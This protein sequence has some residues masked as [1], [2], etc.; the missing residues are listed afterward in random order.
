MATARDPAQF[1]AAGACPV[2]DALQI[3]CKLAV[4]AFSLAAST[5]RSLLG[6]SATRA[7]PLAPAFEIAERGSLGI[8]LTPQPDISVGRVLASNSGTVRFGWVDD[9]PHWL[10]ASGVVG[11]LVA[12]VTRA[13]VLDVAIDDAGTFAFLVSRLDASGRSLAIV[14]EDGGE[15][16][17]AQGSILGATLVGAGPSVV[18]VETPPTSAAQALSR[19]IRWD[20][21]GQRELL[22]EFLESA[23]P[24]TL[25]AAQ[26]GYAASIDLQGYTGNA[27]TEPFAERLLLIEGDGTQRSIWESSGKYFG[28]SES[29]TV[30]SP[31]ICPLETTSQT[32]ADSTP[33]GL[34]AL[35]STSDAKLWLARVSGPAEQ[36]CKWATVSGCFETLPCQ[37]AQRLSTRYTL[38]LFLY[39][40]PDFTTPVF[41]IAL[42]GPADDA[43]LIMK[44]VGTRLSI[45]TATHT[46]AASKIQWLDLETALIP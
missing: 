15:L 22:A 18:Y 23:M 44:S 45:A 30:Q 40:A 46:T 20:A 14:A 36:I 5:E 42:P 25:S 39:R 31:A 33:L 28:C 2:T 6:F 10:D 32:D 9:E 41:E 11:D 21:S 26:N 7:Y 43:A 24:A 19:V 1:C 8:A 3:E 27:Q 29:R 37:C 34:H 12:P 4:S 16:A 38:S 17:V 13:E 35:A